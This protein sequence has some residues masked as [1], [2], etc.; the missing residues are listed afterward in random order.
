MKLITIP[1]QLLALAL[2]S[3]C[4]TEGSE[5]DDAES[6]AP[7]TVIATQID[8]G[9]QECIQ[10]GLPIALHL[11]N[12]ADRPTSR[13]S[14]TFSVNEKNHST[15]LAE[16]T[17]YAITLTDPARKTDRIIQPGETFKVCSSPP[18]LRGSPAGEL[19]YH[20]KTDARFT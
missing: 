14:W 4:S 9:D 1:G 7:A 20:V 18:D 10:Q 11:K 2:L 8:F 15:D 3:A 5:A 17:D 16:F 6:S 12:N 13:V 19:E